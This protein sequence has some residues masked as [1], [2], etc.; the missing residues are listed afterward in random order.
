M[1]WIVCETRRAGGIAPAGTVANGCACQT[2]G[3]GRAG[4]GQPPR[5]A[6]YGPVDCNVRGAK[7]MMGNYFGRVQAQTWY[8]AL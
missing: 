8:Y 4:E 2:P 5:E 6:Q 3:W 1:S 7:G